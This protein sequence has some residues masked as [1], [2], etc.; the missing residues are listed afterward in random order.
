VREFLLGVIGT[1]VFVLVFQWIRLRFWAKNKDEISSALKSKINGDLK[2]AKAMSLPDAISD[3][4][5]QLK[6]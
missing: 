2:D 5:K 4:N 3:F 1:L 6:R